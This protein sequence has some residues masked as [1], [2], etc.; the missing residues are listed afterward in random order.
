MKE[1]GKEVAYVERGDEPGVRTSFIPS[2]Y[3]G[4][5]I[6]VTETFD[7]LLSVEYADGEEC[8][9]LEKIRREE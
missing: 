3:K 7:Y 8:E 2:G 6:K 9:K 4:V 5:W 1:V